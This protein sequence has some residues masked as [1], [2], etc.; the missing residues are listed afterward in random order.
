LSTYYERFIDF[1]C[2]V[3]STP[4]IYISPF[5]FL[6]PFSLSFT[7]LCAVT[8][9]PWQIVFVSSFVVAAAA[10]NEFYIF[11]AP[12][13]VC[14]VRSSCSCMWIVDHP[15]CSYICIFFVFLQICHKYCRTRRSVSTFFCHLSSPPPAAHP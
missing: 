4:P 6:H 8:L 11:I 15:S 2:L 1:R 3:F 5:P 9:L 13:L 7:Y 10:L 12:G 14:I